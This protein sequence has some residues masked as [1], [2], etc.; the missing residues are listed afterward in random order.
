[1]LEVIAV[2]A[3]VFPLG[4]PVIILYGG[5]PKLGV[6]FWG[7][8]SKDYSTLGSILGYPN[9]EKLPKGKYFPSC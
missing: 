1:M 2:F 5:F 4:F 3:Q 8:Y 6:P 7:L 9:F